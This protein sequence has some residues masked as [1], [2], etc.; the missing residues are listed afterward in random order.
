MNK[1][2]DISIAQMDV[3]WHDPEANIAKLETWLSSEPHGQMVVLPEM[4]NT[5]F[6]MAATEMAETME[7]R[8]LQSLLR[9]SREHSCIIVG[10]LIITEEDRYYNRLVWVQPDGVVHTYDKRHLFS[11]TAEPQ[12]F[13]P[14][15]ERIICSA[16]GWRF[17][18]QVCYDL[19]FPVWLRNRGDYDA[20]IVVASWPEVRI[21]AWE[22]LLIAR[23]IEN[24][25]YV[26]GCTRVG[27]DPSGVAHSGHSMIVAPDG[28]VLQKLTNEEGM[29]HHTLNASKLQDFRKKF[30]F[31]E[32]GDDFSILR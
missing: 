29:L 8:T 24:Q 1:D 28:T 3:A 23:A 7:G 20:I 9:L 31:L 18:T 25:C 10:S 13:T 6:T 17:L 12:V 5:G 27:T 2:I 16:N 15:Q 11:L 21:Y 30:P 32:D 19:R 14:G 22:Q 26:I 4:F